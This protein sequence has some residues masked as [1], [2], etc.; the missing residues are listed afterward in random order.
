MK[1]FVSLVLVGLFLSTNISY[2]ATPKEIRET[3]KTIK[4]LEKEFI[5]T[6]ENDYQKLAETSRKISYYCKERGR[7]V[8][9]MSIPFFFVGFSWINR[10]IAVSYFKKAD[11]YDD[12]H[13]FYAIEMYY[14]M[15]GNC[16]LSATPII[17]K[18]G[19]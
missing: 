12:F 7:S 5:N 6:A 11:R 1:R 15:P 13:K 8:S 3:R 14:S 10:I 2:A 4:S 9:M 16:N 17:Y 19:K 18:T